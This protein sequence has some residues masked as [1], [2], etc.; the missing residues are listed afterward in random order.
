LFKDKVLENFSEQFSNLVIPFEKAAPGTMKNISTVNILTLLFVVAACSS[1]YAEPLSTEDALKSFELREGF[2]IELFASEPYILDPV[3]MEFDEQGNVFA[4]EMPDYPFKPEPG[5][6]KGRIVQL[7]DTDRDGRVDQSI[8]FA[9]SLMEATSILPWQGG[10]IV[11]AGSD[12]L[13]LKDTNSDGVAD[14]KEVLFTG[15]FDRNSEAQITNLIFG[16]DNWIYASNNGQA[17]EVKFLRDPNAPSLRVNGADFRFRLERNQFECVT[18]TAQYGQTFDDFGHRFFTQNT[19]HVQQVVVPWKYRR[20]H[21]FLRSYTAVANISDHDFDMFQKTPPPYWRAERTKLRN[22]EFQENKLNQVE[23]ADKHFTGCTGGTIYTGDAFPN[24]FYGTVFTGEVAG[25]LIHRDVLSMTEGSPLFKASRD[26]KERD[27]EFLT[28]T[29]PWFRPA[30]FSQGPDGNLYVMDF[31]RQHIESPFSIPEYLKEDMDFYYGSDLGRIY[32]ISPLSGNAAPGDP[33]NLRNSATLELV[34]LLA[35]PSRWWRTQAQRLLLERQDTSA[36]PHLKSMVES[37]DD[38]RARLHSLYALEGMNALD[39]EIIKKVLSNSAPAVREHALMLSE[40]FPGCL[41]RAIES[42]NDPSIHVSF[43][44]ALSIGNYEG[45]NVVEALG[46]VVEKYGAD[47]WFRA[48]VLTSKV[49]TSVELLRNISERGPFLKEP[50][51]WKLTFVED[52]SY[53]IGARNEKRQVAVFLELVG[54]PQIP[55][56]EKFQSACLKGLMLGLKKSTN[57]ARLKVVLDRVDAVT[58]KNA[59]VL[60]ALKFFFSK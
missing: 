10:L 5:K 35:H 1:K 16:I 36:V 2:R 49:G 58:M 15:F 55:E 43:Q 31:Y 13:Y 42:I 19:L 24:A 17:G 7:K 22:Q 39:I 45:A 40:N 50:D 12:I 6:A 57:D 41:P 47:S 34:K 28:S 14:T 32:R 9:D 3:S 25:N 33:P 30:N 52:L 8:V 4:V 23:F 44:A 46:D 20:R 56:K 54:R 27:R 37:H 60:N 21:K 48:A 11:T 38:A 26:L 59:D 53:A 18:G 29:D 51:R